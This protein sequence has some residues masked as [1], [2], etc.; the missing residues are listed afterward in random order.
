M[1]GQI[2]FIDWSLI[3]LDHLFVGKLV[4]APARARHVPACV[5]S[6]PPLPAP[7]VGGLG[8][9]AAHRGQHRVVALQLAGRRAVGAKPEGRFSN[10]YIDV[11]NYIMNAALFN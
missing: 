8:A 3:F 5:R 4:L 7:G 6:R 10:K 2:A 1:C 11:L 9:H